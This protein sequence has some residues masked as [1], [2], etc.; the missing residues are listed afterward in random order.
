M[1]DPSNEEEQVE[2][3]PAPSLVGKRPASPFSGWEGSIWVAC[4][5][6]KRDRRLPSHLP[7][8]L[9]LWYCEF[10]PDETA[11]K[12]LPTSN[13]P[14]RTKAKAARGTPQLTLTNDDMEEMLEVFTKLKRAGIEQEITLSCGWIATLKKRKKC[15]EAFAGDVYL[16]KHGEPTLRSQADVKRLYGHALADEAVKLRSTYDVE[17]VVQHPEANGDSEE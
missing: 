14:L 15:A 4:E 16:T 11:E 17:E 8:P 1:T 9:G 6:C 10:N 7:V 12:C 5:R 13:V 2:M 3:A